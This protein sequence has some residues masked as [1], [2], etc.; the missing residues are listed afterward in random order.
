MSTVPLSVSNTFFVDALSSSIEEKQTLTRF[1][2]D[3]KSIDYQTA[4][5]QRY[6]LQASAQ[7]L[8]ADIDHPRGRRWRTV[9]CLRGWR[10]AIRVMYSPEIGRASYAGA[11]VCGAAWVCAVC[12]A[13]ITELRRAEIAAAHAVHGAAGGTAMMLSLTVPHE[14][15][16]SLQ[17]VLGLRRGRVRL[18]LRG[19]LHRLRDSRTWRGTMTSLGAVGWIAATEITHGQSGWHPHQHLLLLTGCPEDD[20][21]RLAAQSALA[22]EW[23]RAAV[24]SGLGEPSLER[25]VD[26]RWAWDASRYLAKLGHERQS[27]GADAELARAA[28]KRGRKGSRGP[29]ELLRDACDGYESA[30]L[31]WAEL[32]TTTVGVHQIDWSRGLRVALGLG[33][34]RTDEELAREVDA[35]AIEIAHISRSLWRRVLMLDHTVR[36]RLLEAA[37]ADPAH[38][39]SDFLASL[40]APDAA[41]GAAKTQE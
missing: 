16:Q 35:D 7:S 28:T 10:E 4:R 20:R 2:L 25:G 5:R 3:R 36:V 6:Q 34:E 23:Q 37:E 21:I 8:L 32:I 41:G 9:E 40:D 1:L 30:R 27:W 26:L 39:V 38:G 15:D 14:R 19:A 12:S 18:G 11:C 29:W 13:R 22:R 24:S 17:M 31:L 33:K